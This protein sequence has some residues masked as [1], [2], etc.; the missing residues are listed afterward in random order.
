MAVGFPTKTTYADGDVF[1]ASDI[2][3]TNG[4]INYIDPTSA[5]DGQVLTRDAA[6]PGQ[7]KWDTLTVA[8][9]LG[10]TAGKNKIINGDFRWNQRNFTTTTGDEYGFDRW[11]HVKSGAT[12]TYSLQTFTPGTAPVAGYEAINFARVAVTTGADEARI[13]QKI[14][15]VRTFAG[16][17]VT[18]SFWAK[19]TNPTTAGN[20]AVNFQQAFGSGG[21]PSSVVT[22]AQQTFVLTGNWTRYSLT[23][24]IASISGKTIGTAA[25]TSSL[26]LWIGQGT[27]ISTDAWTLDLWGVQVEAGT[28]ATAFQTASGSIGGELALCQR[29]YWRTGGS[30]YTAVGQGNFESTTLGRVVINLPTSMRIAPTG[31]GWSGLAAYDGASTIIPSAIAIDNATG[32]ANPSNIRLALTVSGATAYRP[33]QF[34]SNNNSA[35]FLDLSAE[36]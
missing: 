23:F 27:S 12:S 25:N 19:G 35:G 29:Y 15:D 1:S 31:L 33:F 13:Q 7:V 10:F 6:S 9:S 28:T 14:E 11:Q 4:T 2:N 30:T 20:L 26:Q 16:Q 8:E 18:V 17:T 22:G 21:S 3:D 34:W 24:A 5:T 36:L 32:M